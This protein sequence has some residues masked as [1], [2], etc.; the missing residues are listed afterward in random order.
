MNRISARTDTARSGSWLAANGV[1]RTTAE[2][3]VGLPDPGLPDTSDDL[4]YG[5]EL[6]VFAENLSISQRGEIL[7]GTTGGVRSSRGD[8]IADKSYAAVAH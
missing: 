5:R 2:G 4:I 3:V 8:A 7:I 6:L 1:L